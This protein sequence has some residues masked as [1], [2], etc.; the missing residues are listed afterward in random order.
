MK[1]KSKHIKLEINILDIIR[2]NGPITK[3][4]ISGITNYNITTII[5]IVNV[6]EEKYKV[7]DISGKDTSEGGQAC[8]TLSTKQ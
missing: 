8:S 3:K 5:N 4:E 2:K 7:V 1:K 6:L